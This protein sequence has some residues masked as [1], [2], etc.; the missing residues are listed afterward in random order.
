MERSATRSPHVQVLMRGHHSE[1][2]KASH[3]RA[4]KT[5]GN[6]RRRQHHNWGEMVRASLN[7][8]PPI[9]ADPRSR[10]PAF[11][12][13]PKAEQDARI[14][15]FRSRYSNTTSV[16]NE[17]ARELRQQGMAPGGLP[18]R[19]T[20]P[21]PPVQPQ[22]GNWF[23]RAFEGPGGQQRPQYFPS[24]IPGKSPVQPQNKLNPAQNKLNPGGFG[25]NP[26]GALESYN[27]DLKTRP[28]IIAPIAPSDA[29]LQGR[30][31]GFYR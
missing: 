17:I 3:G 7:D 10:G 30:G 12:G 28:G 21:N 29:V 25:T 11:W 13:L 24:P 18:P 9:G 15:D 5:G 4:Y 27:K 1:G 2:G 19:S 16:K 23:T 31:Y 20:Q 6:V 26:G 22:S 14:N 8:R